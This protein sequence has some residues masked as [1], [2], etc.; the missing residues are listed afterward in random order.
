[1]PVKGV[2][3]YFKLFQNIK[4]P[5][6]YFAN[7][8]VKT[9]DALLFTTKPNAI[10]FAVPGRL[11]PVFKELFMEDVYNINHFTKKMSSTP[12]VVDIGANAGFFDYLLLSKIPAAQ[13]YAYEPLESNAN[14]IIDT[15]TKNPS[16]KNKIIISQKAVT[17]NKKYAV[18]LFM[19]NTTGNQV[20]AS[21]YPGFDKRNS[22]K[23]SI[24]AISFTEII[25][26]L[27]KEKIDLLK[28]DCEG[29]EFDILFNTPS[30][31]L[32]RISIMLIE[33]HNIDEEN[34]IDVFIEIFK[35]P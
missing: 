24:P 12:L 16:I 20:V 6:K 7:K 5:G 29:S 21:I 28:M 1:M 10:S 25:E 19:E 15:V 17:G 22:K 8:L 32:Q 35:C 2:K 33:V 23:I 31:L 27:P 3:R 26:A 18:D 14:H 30:I 9:K 13:I 11:Y 34:N 4:N